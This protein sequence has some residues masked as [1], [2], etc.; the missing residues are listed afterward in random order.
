MAGNDESEQGCG[1]DW[2]G[3]D[4]ERRFLPDDRKAFKKE[5][6]L[7][8]KRDRS[9]Y[10]K[11]DRDKKPAPKAVELKDLLRGRVLSITP[12]GIAVDCDGAP[13]ICLVK[14]SLKMERE[15]IKNLVAVGDFVWFEPQP[16]NE[17]TILKVEPRTT[18][19]S[20][21]EHLHR[22]KEQL[23]AAN[24][25][26]VLICA[27]VIAPTLKHSLVD[28]YLIAAQQGGM[29]PVIVINK[30]DLLEADSGVSKETR[31]QEGALY[32]EF[33]HTYKRLG[34]PVISTSVSKGIGLLELKERMRDK[35]SVFSGQSGV[36]KSSLINAIFGFSLAVGDVVGRTWK[37]SHTTSTTQ[38]IPLQGGG[39]CVDT[40]GIRSFGLWN[41]T[42]GQTIEYFQ[43]I[44]DRG[45]ACKYA[46]C[47]HCHEP[48]CAVQEAV[49]AGEIS[50]LRFESYLKLLQEEQDID[51]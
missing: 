26:Q 15:R 25:D 42:K 40:P 22:R 45:R 47:S 24:I 37:G 5:R 13:W 21:A 17:G 1:K 2:Y 48:G 32:R 41:L 51:T 44:F 12:Q 7:A 29:Q 11:T 23:I 16:G 18:V 36:G 4:E 3:S 8:S 27:S 10:K 33:V 39:F 50:A 6:K 38:L 19:L 46:G 9:K 30:V 43:E 49:H 14:G 28:R 34:L 35:T 20:R 31:E